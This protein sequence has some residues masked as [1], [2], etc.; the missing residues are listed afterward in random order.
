MLADEDE[1][2]G[3]RLTL[4]PL[5]AVRAVEDHVH[6]LV[7]E[8]LRSTLQR[9]DAFHSKNVP[10]PVAQRRADPFVDGDEIDLAR[11]GDGDTCDGRIV[12]VMGIRVQKAL[13]HLERALQVEGPEVEHRAHVH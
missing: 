8:L 7:H 11:L 3:A 13:V 1:L 12:L 10:T 9:Q 6:A 5:I 2:V 4:G